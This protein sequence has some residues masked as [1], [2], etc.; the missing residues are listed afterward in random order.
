[1]PTGSGKSFV[2]ELAVSQALRDGWVLYLAPTNALTEQIRT[3]LSNGL[4][5][6]NTEIVPFIGDHEYSIF[7]TDRVAEMNVNSVAV[8][9]PETVSYT[10]LTLPTIYSV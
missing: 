10:H 1:M 6:L 2:A 4:S 5:S 3:D 7:S 9:T 8:M